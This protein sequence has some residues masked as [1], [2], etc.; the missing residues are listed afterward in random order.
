MAPTTSTIKFLIG[1]LGVGAPTKPIPLAALPSF[2]GL[3]SEDPNTFLFEFDIVCQGYDYM[4]NAQKLKK[5][6][7]K[8]KGT[9]LRW[10]MGLGGSSIFTWDDMQ[11]TFLEKKQDY[12]KSRNI[13][14][15]LFK[16][17]QKEDESLEDY[18]ERFKYTLQRSCHYDLDNEILKIILLRGFRE[19]SL[20]LLK[21]VG[22]GDISKKSFQVIFELCSQCL[23]GL[24][25]TDA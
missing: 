25:R 4:T 16:F 18:V 13:K 15:E 1:D 7:P 22:K 2:H 10:F 20:E 3:A 12:C 21:I 5:F 19:D 23:R 6:P 17:T 9:T 24:A 8:L 11:T 14:E